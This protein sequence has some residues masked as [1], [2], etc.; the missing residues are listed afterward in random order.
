[1]NATAYLEARSVPVPESG[2]WLWIGCAMKTGWP[3]G[4]CQ[5]NKV[6]WQAHRLAYATFIGEIPDG[7]LVCHKCDVPLCVNPDHLFL[8]TQADNMQD[9]TRKGRNGSHTKPERHPRGARVNTAKVDEATVRH[10]RRMKGRMLL[11]ELSEATGLCVSAV[12]AIQSGKNW[13]HVE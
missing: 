8:G 6:R 4:Q 12:Q 10:I 11:R 2:C 7:M 1:M 3:Y 13:G 9:M 5:V